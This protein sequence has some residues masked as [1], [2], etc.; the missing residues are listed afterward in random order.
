MTDFAARVHLRAIPG[1]SASL[2]GVVGAYALIYGRFP[3]W[4][5]FRCQIESHMKDLG[6][7][8]IDCE[9]LFEIKSSEEFEEGEQLDLYNQLDFYPIQY[10]NIHRYFQDDS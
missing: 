8:F 7:Y 6:Y 3:S 10:K 2:E 4:E 9:E 1:G 5:Q